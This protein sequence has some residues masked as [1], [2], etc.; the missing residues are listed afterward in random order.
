M[1][2][3]IPGCKDIAQPAEDEY[4]LKM[5]LVIPAIQ[6]NYSGTLRILEKNPRKGG[7]IH[8]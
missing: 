8:T 1:S 7:D 4:R 2:Q 6:G 3:V 5:A